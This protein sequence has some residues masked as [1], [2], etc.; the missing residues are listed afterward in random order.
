MILSVVAAAF[1]NCSNKD[2][3]SVDLSIWKVTCNPDPRTS[4]TITA[5]VP[6]T[7]TTVSP[8]DKMAVFVGNECRGV[9]SPKIYEN[10]KKN[11]FFLLVT[12]KQPEDELLSQKLTLFYYSA[13][14]DRVYKGKDTNLLL[15]KDEMIGTIE[16][17]FMTEWTY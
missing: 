12:I 8:N 7:L 14:K 17:P 9:A 5:Q 4:M 3:D 6:D 10:G 16:K 1:I 13:T 11:I 15:E 2:D